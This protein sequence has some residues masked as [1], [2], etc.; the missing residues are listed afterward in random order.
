M[1]SLAH[2]LAAYLHDQGVGTFPHTTGWAINV[3]HEP[4]D[5]ADS[6]TIYDTGGEGPDTDQLDVE[7]PT[8]QV[9]VRSDSYPDAYAK[10]QAIRDMLIFGP[11]DLEESVV[12]LVQTSGPFSLGLD[13]KNRHLLTANYRA[14]RS[15]KE[16]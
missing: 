5:P 1:R 4:G 13:D 8:I 9:R 15:A 12:R 3:A 16:S 10:H 7:R 2:D 11:L 6:I 14:R